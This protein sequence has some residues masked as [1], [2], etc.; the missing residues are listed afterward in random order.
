MPDTSTPSEEAS[1]LAV[2]RP[3]LV[4]HPLLEAGTHRQAAGITA[5]VASSRRAVRARG[6]TGVRALPA[7]TAVIRTAA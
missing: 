5:R 7:T 1:L 3:G 2:C 6:L 4:A